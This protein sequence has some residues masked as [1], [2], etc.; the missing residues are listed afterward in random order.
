MDQDNEAIL[1][2]I[3]SLLEEELQEQKRQR[4]ELEQLREDVNTTY[5]QIL[6]MLNSMIESYSRIARKQFRPLPGGIVG[7]KRKRE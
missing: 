1:K 3:L 5:Q 6:P 4:K 2:R 7:Y